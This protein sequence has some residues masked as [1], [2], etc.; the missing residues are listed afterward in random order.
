VALIC[1]YVLNNS[2]DSVSSVSS[3]REGWL[4]KVRVM[5]LWE[6]PSFLNPEQPNSI[7]MVLIDNNVVLIIII[8]F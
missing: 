7:E 3:G 2:F 4:L 8:D 6:V 5:R 1:P